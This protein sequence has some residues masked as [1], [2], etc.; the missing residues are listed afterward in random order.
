MKKIDKT[1]K[2]VYDAGNYHL[3]PIYLL[4]LYYIVWWT[5]RSANTIY[6]IQYATI[7]DPDFH[8]N[9]NI[10]IEFVTFQYLL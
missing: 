3:D 7:L 10:L 8:K 5:I 6:S 1:L 2:F 9:N 4:I